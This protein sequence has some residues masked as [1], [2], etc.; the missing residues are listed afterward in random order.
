MYSAISEIASTKLVKDR[1]DF[2]VQELDQKY[3]E[4]EEQR[5]EL[6]N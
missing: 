4:C 1:Y 3:H 6:E 2:E 5:K